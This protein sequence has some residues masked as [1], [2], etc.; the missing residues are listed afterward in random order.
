MG[1]SQKK[2]KKASESRSAS[3]KEESFPP[4]TSEDLEKI[5]D[6]LFD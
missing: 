2:E 3:V 4:L 5:K 1:N 6:V